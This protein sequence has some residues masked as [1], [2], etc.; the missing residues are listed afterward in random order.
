M[1]EQ[2]N[3]HVSN[4]YEDVEC[5]FIFNLR[6]TDGHTLEG[7]VSIHFPL[8]YTPL[9]PRIGE[10]YVYETDLGF[11]RNYRIT[12]LSH[13]IGPANDPTIGIHVIVFDTENVDVN[14]FSGG[15]PSNN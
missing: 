12:G 13:A 8:G 5:T 10:L 15:A 7:K 9:M 1:T 14:V 4:D 2:D 6:A 11:A 3:P